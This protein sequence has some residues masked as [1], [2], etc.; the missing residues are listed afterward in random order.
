MGGM[1]LLSIAFAAL[2]LSYA[3]HA[4]DAREYPE[5]PECSGSG[6]LKKL[7]GKF[8][9][10]KCPM[11]D[12]EGTLRR[13]RTFFGRDIPAGCHLCGACHGKGSQ[14]W[15]PC[16]KCKKSELPGLLKSGMGFRLCDG[17]S[18]FGELPGTKCKI[19]AGIGYLKD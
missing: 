11:C 16:D 12:G 4:Q 17:C 1:R 2:I 6:I 18:G 5:C 7:A 14:Q 9:G 8:P 10:F 3:S 15:T 13:P 19:C